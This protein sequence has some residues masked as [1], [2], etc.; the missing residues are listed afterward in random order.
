MFVDL[1]K[2][3]TGSSIAKFRENGITPSEIDRIA[4]T[5]KWQFSPR[6][7]EKENYELLPIDVANLQND[8]IE[9]YLS[10]EQANFTLNRNKH[11]FC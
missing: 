5:Q 9:N 8:C 3:G 10:K 2:Y 4:K 11:L 7:L 6:S 1:A